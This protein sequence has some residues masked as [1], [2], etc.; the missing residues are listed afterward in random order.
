MNKRIPMTN[1]DRAQ[2][3]AF[4]SEGFEALGLTEED[5]GIFADALIFSELRFH[6]G[7]GQG[8]ARLR[9]YHERI[10]NGEVNP[11][12]GW[13]IVKEGPALANRCF[14][15]GNPAMG[16]GFLGQ[17]IAAAGRHL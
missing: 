9:R 1:V 13:S 15:F 16:Q 10:G 14:G 5:A 2:L 6:P 12:A 11:R 7:Q 4:V 8:V 17:R 3:R